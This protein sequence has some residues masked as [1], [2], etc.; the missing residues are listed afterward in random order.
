M[1]VFKAAP[2]K[3]GKLLEVF[4]LWGVKSPEFL[5]APHLCHLP[6]LLHSL[7]Y[8]SVFGHEEGTGHLACLGSVLGHSA[9]VG[10]LQGQRV[11]S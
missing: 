5:H 6:W 1:V 11:Q 8:L 7:N 3:E 2:E 4:I 10:L 9:G